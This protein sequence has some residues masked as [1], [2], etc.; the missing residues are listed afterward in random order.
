LAADGVV[1]FSKADFYDP[2]WWARLAWLEDYVVD[3]NIARLHEYRLQR[4][5]AMIA[6]GNTEGFNELWEASEWNRRELTAALMPWQ[7]TG[8]KNLA[9]A[10]PAM[11]QRYVDIF[12]DPQS[13]EFK[14]SEQRLL[15]YWKNKEWQTNKVSGSN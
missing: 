15:D 10:I 3:M 8:P 11:R 4:T 12:G 7:E 2:N 1:D 5:L 9:E 13:P 6:A 14:E